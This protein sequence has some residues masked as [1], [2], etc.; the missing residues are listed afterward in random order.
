MRSS[1]ERRANCTE[2]CDSVNVE[3]KMNNPGE[4]TS[5]RCTSL[6]LSFDKRVTNYSVEELFGC[7]LHSLTATSNLRFLWTLALCST[8]SSC[9]PQTNTCCVSVVHIIKKLI[10]FN[11]TYL[12]DIVRNRNCGPIPYGMV[13]NDANLKIYVI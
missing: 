5:V 2:Q 7:C 10:N 1:K 11:S 6:T 8:V 4:E 12:C 9:F 13:I 3:I